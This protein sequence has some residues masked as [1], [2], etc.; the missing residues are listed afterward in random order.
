MIHVP[1]LDLVA[2]MAAYVVVG[3]FAIR[4]GWLR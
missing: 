1:N 2:L 4:R 3:L